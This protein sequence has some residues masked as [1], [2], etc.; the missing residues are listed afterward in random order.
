MDLVIGALP[1]PE[2]DSATVEIVE[3]KGIGHPDTI[4]DAL[5]EEVSLALCRFYRERFGIILHHN[6]DKVLLRGGQA[7]AAFGGGEVTQPIDV[8]LAG[9]AVRRHEGTTIPVD[10]IAVEACRTWLRNNIR[11]LDPVRHVR[12]HCLIRP[13]S[14]DLTELFARL[15]QGQAPLANDTSCGLGYAPL[16][17]TEETVLAIDRALTAAPLR[18]ECPAFGEDTKL[19][20]VRHGRRLELTAACAHVARH[21]PDMVRYRESKAWLTK[22]IADLAR[23]TAAFETTVRVNTADGETPDSLY[24]TVTGTSAESGDDGEAG[25]GNRVNGLIT[26]YRPM[27]MESVAGKNPVN[28][29]GKLYNIAAGMIAEAIVREVPEAAFAACYLVSRIGHAIDDPQIA[30]IR[31]RPRAGAGT[32]P[33]ARV[34]RIVRQHLA[35]LV[36]MAD[37]LSAGVVVIGGW[38]LRRAAPSSTETNR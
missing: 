18:E 31:I 9:R 11:A 10:D 13:G 1:E 32:V 28:H 37:E 7:R 35:S 16:S 24:L 19:M 4:C 38:P 23:R 6:V 34:E 5:A 36:N 3:R 25:R 22:R 12:F 15:R 21:V 29:V 20:A 8:Y 30:D 27:T 17:G 14:V 26:P 2:A 33:A